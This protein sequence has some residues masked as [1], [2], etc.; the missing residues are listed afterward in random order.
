[1][2]FDNTLKNISVI[3]L[4]SVLL[5]EETGIPGVQLSV[6]V[7]DKLYH[8]ML[9][10]LHRAM[11]VIRNQAPVT[12]IVVNSL[13]IRSRPRQFRQIREAARTWQKKQNI[14]DKL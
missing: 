12:Q 7:A 11:N 6:P 2:V 8:I 1:M 5:V 13:T 9:Y 10:R 14:G 3:S 4:W